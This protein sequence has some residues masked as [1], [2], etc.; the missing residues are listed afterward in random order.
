MLVFGAGTDYALLLIARYR[1]ELRREHTRRVAMRRAWVG[2]APAIAASGATVILALLTL[3]FAQTGSSRAIGVGGA[4][5]I[6]TAPRFGLLAR[7]SALVVCP[8]GIFWP[9]VPKVDPAG[10]SPT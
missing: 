7:P 4:I 2:A 10:R 1:E 8:R 5:G 6:L 3:L 9:L